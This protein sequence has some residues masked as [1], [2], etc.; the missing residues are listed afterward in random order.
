MQIISENNDKLL[1]LQR[2][3]W[4]VTPK[5]LLKKLSREA[6]SYMVGDFGGIWF[7]I[8][9]D[10]IVNGTPKRKATTAQEGLIYGGLDAIDQVTLKPY[11]IAQSTPSTPCPE[12]EDNADALTTS[13]TPLKRTPCP[14]TPSSPKGGPATSSPPPAS[15][16]LSAKSTPIETTIN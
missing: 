4:K 7:E 11:E 1:Q 16:A 8:T 6:W 9:Y 10:Q 14:S 2:L 5:E 15:P 3:D 12:Y 13:S